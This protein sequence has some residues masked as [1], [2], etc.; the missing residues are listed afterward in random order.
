MTARLKRSAEALG[1]K[2]RALNELFRVPLASSF[3]NVPREDELEL[4]Q[5]Y[6]EYYIAE[7]HPLLASFSTFSVQPEPGGDSLLQF[8]CNIH[9]RSLL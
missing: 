2:C 4:V 7:K 9:S 5:L 1:S 3:T 6:A 8:R